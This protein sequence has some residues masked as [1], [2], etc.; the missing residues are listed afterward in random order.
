MYND[1]WHRFTKCDSKCTISYIYMY[2]SGTDICVWV[3]LWKLFTIKRLFQRGRLDDRKKY[4]I[5]YICK[6]ALCLEFPLRKKKKREHNTYKQSAL[7][8]HP[9]TLKLLTALMTNKVCKA[10]FFHLTN[11]NTHR[12]AHWMKNDPKWPH[13]AIM[14]VTE[15]SHSCDSLHD[16]PF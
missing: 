2:F 15:I 4:A 6:C 13:C 3:S 12:N 5:T 14:T 7:H 8:T 9:Q 16:T 11:V 10:L 1:N